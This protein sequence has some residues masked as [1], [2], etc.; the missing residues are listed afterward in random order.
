MLTHRAP[1]IIQRDWSPGFTVDL[2]QKSNAAVLDAATDIELSL[3]LTE[4]AS[5]Y[6]ALLQGKGLGDEGHHA[7]I[8][9]M[10]GLSGV[11]VGPT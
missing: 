9:I 7:L 2:Q 4:M 10:E 5:N 3:P 6:Y 11:K 1:Q 8:K